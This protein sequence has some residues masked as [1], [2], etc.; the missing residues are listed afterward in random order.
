MKI[1]KSGMRFWIL[2]SSVASFLLGWVML[3]HAPKPVQSSATASSFTLAPLQPL[4]FNQNDDDE[5]NFQ[6]GPQIIQRQPF[7]PSFRTGGS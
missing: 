6:T 3:A 2:V 1:L 4:N 7:A 5:F